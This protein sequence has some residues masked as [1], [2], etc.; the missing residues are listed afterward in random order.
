[1]GWRENG[2]FAGERDWRPR[3]MRDWRP[4][5]EE[6]GDQRRRWRENGDFAGERDVRPRME[7]ERFGDSRAEQECRVQKGVTGLHRTLELP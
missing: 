4:R 6:F 1:M 3:I 5:M 7:I 2:D